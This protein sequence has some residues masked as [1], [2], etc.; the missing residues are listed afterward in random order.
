MGDRRASLDTHNNPLLS[1]CSSAGKDRPIPLEV[2][3][4]IQVPQCLRDDHEAIRASSLTSLAWIPMTRQLL[5]AVPSPGTRDRA[6]LLDSIACCWLLR[7]MDEPLQRNE[8][9]TFSE[10]GSRL[11]SIRR[12]FMCGIYHH[13]SQRVW[14]ASTRY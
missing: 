1:N 13:I 10:I 14:M 9:F 11:W 5:S 7:R 6:V 8:L 12:T 2:W 3:E 4:Y